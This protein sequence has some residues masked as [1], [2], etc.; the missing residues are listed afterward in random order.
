[1]LRKSIV[2]VL[3][4]WL[5][6]GT[7]LL[8]AQN[9]TK[10]NIIGPAGLQVNSYTGSLFYQRTDL[11][12]PGRGL[13]LDLTFSYSNNLRDQ[14]YGYGRGF[15]MPY[16]LHYYRDSVFTVVVR[17]DGRKDSFRPGQGTSFTP[18]T[19]FFDQLE[20]YEKGKLRLTTKEGMVYFFEDSTHRKLTRL[21][22]R[23]GNTIR[24]N[25]AGQYP[26]LITDASGRSI[27]LTWAGNHLKEITE[28]NVSPARKLVYQ[29]D[30]K[31]NLT[32]VTNFEEK[33]TEYKYD[34]PGN[35]IDVIDPRKTTF[36][37]IYN[38]NGAVDRLCSPITTQSLV[39]NR[40]RRTTYIVEEGASGKQTTAY[41]FDDQGRV[42]K[43]T[44]NCCGYNVNYTYDQ[45]NNVIQLTDANGQNYKFTYDSR[46]NRLSETDPLGNTVKLTYE[47]KYNQV[48]S[49]TDKNGNTTQFIYDDK[50]SLTQIMRPLG[51]TE[52]Y[53]YNEFGYPVSYKDGNGNT[54]R[55]EYDLH[56]N[57]TRAVD[58]LGHVTQ[59]LYD[60]RS[61]N[62]EIID[63]RGNKTVY[64]YDVMDRVKEVKDALN[65]VT[66]FEYDENG[67]QKLVIDAKENFTRF[68]YDELDRLVLTTDVLGQ[69]IIRGYDAQ[70]NLVSQTDQNGNQT[71]YNYDNL[72]R[73]SAVTNA[74]G[75]T[76]TYEYDGNG[77][78]VSM[79][80][81]GGNLTRN[82]Y[83]ALNRLTATDDALGPV[84]IFEYDKQGN[85]LSRTDANGN[86]TR[87][88]YDALYRTLTETDP[89]GNAET[90]Q[91][92]R[93][94]NLTEVKDRNGYLTKHTYDALDRKLTV[95]DAMG[96]I[97]RSEYD[98]SDNLI[99][100]TDANGHATAYT[101]DEL[102]RVKAE[103]YADQTTV[104]YD[105]DEVGN[106]VARTDNKGGT[107]RY[108]YDKLYRLT[109]R[110]YP[111]TPDD[112]FVYDAAGRMERA[113]NTYA[114]L[115]FK[116]DPANRLLSE[117]LN[118][119]T[120]AYAYDI[121][122]RRRQITYPSGRQILEQRDIRSRLAAVSEGNT[123]I[124][125]WEYDLANR[126]TALRYGNGTLAN[127]QYDNN[128]RL[129]ALTNNPSGFLDYRYAYDKA[130]NRLAEE[131]RH[132]P[133][134]SQAYAYDKLHR[135]VDVATGRLSGNVIANPVGKT[136]YKLDGVGNRVTVNENGAATSYTV[137][138]MN[139]Y[140]SVASEAGV[141]WAYDDNGNLTNNGTFQL[142][143]DDRNKLTSVNDANV[144]TYQY[145]PLGRRVRKTAKG[146]TTDFYYDGDRVIEE[147]SGGAVTT[148]TYGSWIDDV[149]TMQ[150]GGDAYYYHKNALGSVTGLS[151]KAGLLKEYYE[152]DAYGA[153]TV[154]NAEFN[155]LA[156]SAL[157]NRYL[158]TGRELDEETGF[159]YYRN[160]HY[161]PEHGRFL[162]RDPLGYIDGMGLYEYVKNSPQVYTDPLGLQRVS[163]PP[164]S[165]LNPQDLRDISDNNNACWIVPNGVPPNAIPILGEEGN[166]DGYFLDA[167]G[168]YHIYDSK[169]NYVTLF[170]L[171]LEEPLFNPLDVIGF[172]AV[173]L[174]I[175]YR[176]GGFTLRY[177]L[178][179]GVGATGDLSNPFK[180]YTL[181]HIDEAFQ[182]HVQSGKL[183]LR[184]A[185]PKTGAKAYENT[186]SG[187][188]YNLDPGGKYGRKLEGPH[189][190]VNYP[191]PKPK[192][193]PKKKLPVGGGF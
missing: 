137:N 107:T 31:G 38:R 152:Y 94:G 108:E 130:G 61:R 127:Y 88:T 113:A 168:V 24:I 165:N 84:A 52:T 40:E 134:F 104:K 102:D 117:T 29:H 75:E 121:A 184:Y 6:A 33:T 162:Q 163:N 119:K 106:L 70:G 16:N 5:V 126:R 95:T 81:P 41:Q 65:R 178:Q 123:T 28:A 62:T 192:I 187:Y 96:G 46:G 139:E 179:K 169:G 36:N 155:V 19:G 166:I 145:D 101:Y 164:L 39:Y 30:D 120:T 2:Q 109:K 170:E 18:P 37:I 93:N 48:T 129:T 42:V 180:N 34:A 111:N 151:D 14:D 7:S 4:L 105:Y 150:R 122:N 51:V 186:K 140:T 92:D 181:R 118:G 54:F 183:E 8:P 188:S 97:T 55:Y 50:G 156:F 57:L 27:T 110:D 63:P 79:R 98:G 171:G 176:S 80:L 100:V 53:T 74:V 149:L 66:K 154:M 125:R 86:A 148:F 45:D 159:Y 73:V 161:D 160:R 60:T 32:K 182:K 173:G 26:S 68:A 147:H 136:A 11:L 87:Y 78:L 143:Y 133:D 10:P 193:F 189:I 174:K 131:K 83:D 1:M 15:T 9:I 175:I 3:W 58:P 22:D 132:R 144:A 23:Y 69:Q 89:L 112:E 142:A 124:A 17:A 115:S 91:Y 12:L 71:V 138:E 157:G 158:Y 128:D 103:T 21:A 77:N 191:K 85:L 114:T 64:T 76:T 67:N 44:G 185:N 13:S 35:L 43:K 172:G 190:D 72:N 153:V 167:G 25:Y 141:N 90:Y 59:T 99:K 116:Y 146:V 177:I 49:V 56:G 82:T 135:L 47:P 20:A